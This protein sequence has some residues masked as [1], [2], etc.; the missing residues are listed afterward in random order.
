MLSWASLLSGLVK[1]GNLIAG[2]IR[3]A[4][5]RLDGRNEVVAGSAIAAAKARNE[6]D[7]IQT[8]KDAEDAFDRNAPDRLRE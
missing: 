8:A 5:L 2:M 4:R 1:F 7:A 6:A 3:D